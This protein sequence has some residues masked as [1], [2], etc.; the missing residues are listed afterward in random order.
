MLDFVE[1]HHSQPTCLCDETPVAYRHQMPVPKYAWLSKE[2]LMFHPT[3]VVIAQLSLLLT[4]LARFSRDRTGNNAAAFFGHAQAAMIYFG[5]SAGGH[6]FV[7]PRCYQSS[8]RPEQS[9]FGA[10]L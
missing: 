5:A 7:M 1:Q 4:H 2:A 8:K 3:L 6:T 10:R 9:H